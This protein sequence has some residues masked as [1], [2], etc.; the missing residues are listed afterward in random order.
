MKIAKAYGLRYASDKTAESTI[1]YHL[2]KNGIARREPAAHSRKATPYIVD[3]WVARYQKGESLKQ[4]AGDAVDSV[5]VYNHLRKRG[6]ETEGQ[7]GGASQCC[8]K[9]RKDLLRRRRDGE[10]VPSWIHPW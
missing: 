4:I 8:E 7:G 10:G 9:I 2:K 3:E 1:L 5:T 6:G